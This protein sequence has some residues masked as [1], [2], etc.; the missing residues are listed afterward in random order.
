M[1][2]LKELWYSTFVPCG[3]V[4]SVI[5]LYVI[6]LIYNIGIITGTVKGDPIKRMVEKYIFWATDGLYLC[7]IK[8]DYLD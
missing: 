2:L 4:L 6:A 7:M 8:L 1:R 3:I 5:P